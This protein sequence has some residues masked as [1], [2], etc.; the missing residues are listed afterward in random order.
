MDCWLLHSLFI[1]Y[2]LIVDQTIYWVYIHQVKTQKKKLVNNNKTPQDLGD[3]APKE[4]MTHKVLKLH[5]SPGHLVYFL[6]I[7]CTW[8]F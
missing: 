8:Y 6:K 5:L 2:L 3:Q 4:Y 1:H 7:L